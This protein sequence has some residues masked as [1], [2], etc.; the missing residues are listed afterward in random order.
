GFGRMM[1]EHAL[2]AFSKGNEMF[3]CRVVR[4]DCRDPLL[5]YYESCGFTPTGKNHS[6]ALN[7]MIAII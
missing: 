5:E 4:L 1:I 6:N 2:D 3:G 7:Q